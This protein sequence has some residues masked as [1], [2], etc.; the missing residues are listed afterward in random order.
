MQTDPQP[1][2]KQSRSKASLSES[3]ILIQN[4]DISSMV[5]MGKERKSFIIMKHIY[6]VYQYNETQCNLP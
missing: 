2:D 4:Y 5:F 3:F 1:I 6:H